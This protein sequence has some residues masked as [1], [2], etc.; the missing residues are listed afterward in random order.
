MEFS[1]TLRYAAGTTITA[2]VLCY[3]CIGGMECTQVY[4]MDKNLEMT[5]PAGMNFDYY[6]LRDSEQQKELE[7]FHAIQ[8]FASNILE[9]IKDLD[10]A[11][12]KTVDDHF[13]EM[14]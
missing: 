9:N 3:S 1:S 7:K 13:W 11:F 10:P 8:S 14:I 4:A 12:S 6:Q 5:A 2:A